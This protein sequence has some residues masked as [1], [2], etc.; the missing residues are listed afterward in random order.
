M[1]DYCHTVTN[2]KI[3]GDLFHSISGRGAFR[4]FKNAV[5]RHGIEQNWY[6]F[7]DEAYKEIAREWCKE[8]GITWREYNQ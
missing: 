7:K 5:R 6:R 8:N 2:P 4:R 1:T 3:A